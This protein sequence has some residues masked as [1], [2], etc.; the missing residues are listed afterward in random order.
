MGFFDFLKSKKKQQEDNSEKETEAVVQL[1]GS[2]LA[3]LEQPETRFTEEYREFL[4][5]QEAAGRTAPPAEEAGCR[6]VTE[7]T[8]QA[9]TEAAEQAVTDAAEAVVFD[10]AADAAADAAVYAGGGND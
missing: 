1:D 5:S 3:G 4:E 7:A 10:T 6:A 2:S 8:E 9:V